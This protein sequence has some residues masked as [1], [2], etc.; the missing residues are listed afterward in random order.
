MTRRP[1][2]RPV[3]VFSGP[4]G[5]P[6]AWRNPGGRPGPRSERY[7]EGRAALDRALAQDPTSRP[8]ASCRCSRIGQR[9]KLGQ[10]R[11]RS[12]PRREHGQADAG[13]VWSLRW[14]WP[15]SCSSRTAAG[16]WR[17]SRDGGAVRFRCRQR[18]SWKTLG[19]SQISLTLNTY[20]HVVPAVQRGRPF[21]VVGAS[22]IA[23]R[24]RRRDSGCQ[25]DELGCQLGCQIGPAPRR[26][27]DF[28][29]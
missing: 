15:T 23:V 5:M 20:A 29:Q 24:V 16:G 21:R 10:P 26:K 1:K 6:S 11:T 2:H 27:V 19:H 4:G 3:R 14:N 8:R 7:E 25:S 9:A 22:S 17:A 13:T 18:R 28:P 12:R